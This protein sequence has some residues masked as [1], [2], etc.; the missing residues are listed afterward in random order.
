MVPVLQGVRWEPLRCLLD[1]AIPSNLIQV[2]LAE[3]CNS[4]PSPCSA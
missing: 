1:Q 3:G 4:P 2:M